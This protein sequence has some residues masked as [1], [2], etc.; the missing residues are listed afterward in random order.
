MTYVQKAWTPTCLLLWAL[1][2]MGC[3]PPSTQAQTAPPGAVTG[4]AGGACTQIP[5]IS[6][7]ATNALTGLP[8]GKPSQTHVQIDVH[9]DG[10]TPGKRVLITMLSNKLISVVA[11]S[12][13]GFNWVTIVKGECGTEMTA[14]AQDWNGLRSNTA[15]V[16]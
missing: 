5:N 13:G 6:A 16:Q 2:E 11:D 4:P 1:C 10:F 8:G 12:L 3:L 15:E 9:G 14:S 7:D